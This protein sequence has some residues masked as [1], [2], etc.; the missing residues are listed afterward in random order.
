L[1]TFA[2]DKAVPQNFDIA[3]FFCILR[4]TFSKYENFF[5]P[6]FKPSGTLGDC[7]FIFIGSITPGDLYLVYGYVV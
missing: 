7:G 5:A 2:R 6:H 3:D 4:Q 1:K